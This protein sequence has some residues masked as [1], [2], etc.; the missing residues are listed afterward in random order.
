VKEISHKILAILMSFVVL[1]S[2]TSFA[3]TKHFC[4]D[5]LVDTAIFTKA[6]SCGM[7]VEK[8]S[9]LADCSNLTMDCCSDQQIVKNAQDELQ[10]QIDKISF[11]QK[12]FIA[13]F[14]YSY[15]NLYKGLDKKVSY[16]E[17]YD[18]PVVTNQLYKIDETYL[19]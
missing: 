2:T 17:V 1:F 16:F 7:E 15:I 18:P 8:T 9:S 5:T 3:I 4:G 13:S 10:L 14:V 11:E 19:I 12:V 6:T